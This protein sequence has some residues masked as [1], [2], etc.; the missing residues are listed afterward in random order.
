[1]AVSRGKRGTQ[2]G[3]AYNTRVKHIEHKT[4]KHKNSKRHKKTT[5]RQHLKKNTST[6]K[7]KMMKKQ[8]VRWADQ[9]PLKK[10]ASGVDALACP[11]LF[12]FLDAV[13]A[14]RKRTGAAAW[15]GEGEQSSFYL[16]FVFLFSEKRR[17]EERDGGGEGGEKREGGRVR[18]TGD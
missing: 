10:K 16:F 11:N 4:S 13:T 17:G 15:S 9:Q 8:G 6:V 12:A 18:K 2:G 7:Q 14:E 1:M 3:Q 5:R